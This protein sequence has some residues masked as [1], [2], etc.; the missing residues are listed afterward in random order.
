MDSINDGHIINIYIL[1]DFCEIM[2]GK[3]EVLRLNPL[4]MF[5]ILCFI[6][7]IVIA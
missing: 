4:L 1:Y 6:V 5:I 2:Y 3:V 7:I